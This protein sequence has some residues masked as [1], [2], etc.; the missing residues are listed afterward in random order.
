MIA[1]VGGIAGATAKHIF[2]F[3]GKKAEQKTNTRDVLE[4][5]IV[6]MLDEIRALSID[7]WSQDETSK[8]KMIAARIVALNDHLPDLYIQLFEKK[9]EVSRDLDI[10]MNQ[11]SEATTGGCFQQKD[12]KA[13]LTVIA[14][15]E[16]QAMSLKVTVRLKKAKLPYPWM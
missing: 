3:L 7:Y 1:L 12:R 8:T 2:T 4:G 15:I 9:L 16:K 10:A 6:E 11:L 14:A 5:L 13:D